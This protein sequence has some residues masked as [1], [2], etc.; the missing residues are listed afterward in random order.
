MRCWKSRA[1][2]LCWTTDMSQTIRQTAQR[3]ER[4]RIHLLATGGTIAASASQDGRTRYTAGV[5]GPQDLIAAVPEIATIAE[6]AVEQIA[7]VGSQNISHDIWLT[8]ARRVQILQDDD[9]VDGVVITHGTDTIEET[10]FF[11]SLV[12][13]RRKPVVLVGAMRPADA[14]SADGPGNLLRAVALAGYRSACAY[15]ALVVMNDSVY[16]AREVQ[17]IS[18]SGVQAFA[19]PNT[20]PVAVMRGLQPVFLHPSVPAHP[21]TEQGEVGKTA[22]ARREA[23]S[24]APFDLNPMQAADLPEVAIIHCHAGQHGRSVRDAAQWADG[25]VI[26]GVGEGNATDDMFAAIRDA[27]RDGVVVVRASRCSAG[28]VVRSGEVDDDALG[29]VASGW[30]NP[31]KARV[32]LMLA[33]RDTRRSDEIQRIFDQIA[34]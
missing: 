23:A 2:V 1:W 18:A 25:I 8:L 20:G 22:L 12:C 5:I 11:L 13:K 3:E 16:G 9:S 7:A 19:S 30:L 33:L 34:K 15:G 4:P 24:D 26:A 32:L 31:A 28:A 29:T 27:V 14:A 21:P 6:L 10:A 17:K